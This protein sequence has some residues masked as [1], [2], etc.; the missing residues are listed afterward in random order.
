MDTRKLRAHID[1][2]H[3]GRIE[4]DGWGITATVD[5][6]EDPELIRE[7]VRRWNGYL[8]LV[9]HLDNLLAELE[10]TGAALPATVQEARQALTEQGWD[11]AALGD[12]ADHNEQQEQQHEL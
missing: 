6:A 2:D 3:G 11:E 10:D 7:L 4:S 8:A 5:H 9:R 1:H 12:L